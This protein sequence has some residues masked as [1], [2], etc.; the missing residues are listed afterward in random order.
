MSDIPKVIKTKKFPFHNQIIE[1]YLLE[2]NKVVIDKKEMAKIFKC[3]ISENAEEKQ[4]MDFARYLSNLTPL[5]FQNDTTQ[6]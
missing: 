6:K 2:N 3:I 4:V 1:V 5:D